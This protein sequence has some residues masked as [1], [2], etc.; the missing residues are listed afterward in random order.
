MEELIMNPSTMDIM[1][2][3]ERAKV[4]DKQKPYLIELLNDQKQKAF[5]TG[6]VVAF[7]VCAGAFILGSAIVLF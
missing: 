7:C 5:A 3:F 2:A 6:I 4:K 1:V